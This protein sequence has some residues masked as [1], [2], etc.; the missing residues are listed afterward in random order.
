VVPIESLLNSGRPRWAGQATPDLDI[1]RGAR[2]VRTSEPKSGAKLAEGNVKL[3]TGGDTILTRALYNG[4]GAFNPQLKLTM[5]G[6][7][8][9]VID[10]TDEAIWRR[11]ILVPWNETIAN[12]DVFL[13]AKLKREASGILNRLLEGFRVWV[14]C[15]LQVPQ[16]IT[17]YTEEFRSESDQIGRFL[18]SCTGLHEKAGQSIVLQVPSLD[19]NSRETGSDQIA[20]NPPIGP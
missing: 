13:L 6:N 5:S 18:S 9:P 1:L 3:L 17:Q 20:P 16:E 8:C 14:E 19:G 7:Y 10:G 11:L 15:G 2:F 4:Y 12:P